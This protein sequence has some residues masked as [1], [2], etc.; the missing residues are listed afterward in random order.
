[1]SKEEGGLGR[2]DFPLAADEDGAASR[3][4]GV[5]VVRQH[6][7]LRGLFLIDP[8]GV[9]QFQVVHSVSIGRSPGEILRVLD[10]LQ[11]GGLCPADRPAGGPPLDISRELGP[12]RVLGH[13][14]I[15]ARL[16][17]GSF[18]TV[19][20]AHDLRLDRTVA[21]KVLRPGSPLPPEAFLAE[22]RAAAALNH[23]NVC[24]IHSVEADLGAPV[25]VMEH[26]DGRPISA[27]LENGALPLAQVVDLGRQIAQAMA[28]AHAQGVIHGDLKPANI[29][30]TVAGSAKVMDFGMARR[31][32]PPPQGDETSLWSPIPAGGLS[33]TPA[34]MAP[35]QARGAPASAASDVFS[36]GLVLYEM[37][38]GRRARGQGNLLEVL[39]RI[40]QDDAA[41]LADQ[42]PPPLAGVLAQ[43]LAADPGR[44]IT[45]AHMAERLG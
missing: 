16:G 4:Y 33:G 44:R 23:P 13:Y 19:F 10:G 45:M 42:T 36:L 6:L 37:A 31:H 25:I 8:N 28:A 41:R 15:E 40:D 29:L 43:A 3:A 7:A 27:L 18:G 35:E 26:V 9:L 32:A 22:A 1:M 5:Y 11:M 30:V 17:A 12:N 39:R 21:L 38:T 24:I 14:R 34:Y 20:R 2:L